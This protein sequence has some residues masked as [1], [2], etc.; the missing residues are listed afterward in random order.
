MTKRERIINAWDQCNAAGG[1]RIVISYYARSGRDVLPS[2]WV[3]FR[4][5][6]GVT[7]PTDPGAPWYNAGCKTFIP[8]GRSRK[9]G[10]DQ[11]IAWVKEA[12]GKS[13]FVRNRM[14]DYAEKEVN[15]KF[16]IPRRDA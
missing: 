4:Y 3:V 11:A 14:G 8:A 13:E 12:Y 2:R 9:E 10:L 16:P 6:A 7:V 1:D 15:D 5:I